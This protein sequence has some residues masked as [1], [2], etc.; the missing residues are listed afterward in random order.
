MNRLIDRM[1]DRI[2]PRETASACSGTYF[3]DAAGHKGYWYRYCCPDSGCTWSKVR[4]SC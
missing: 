2:A 4:N 1:I 3:C